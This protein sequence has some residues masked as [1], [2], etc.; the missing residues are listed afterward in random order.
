[1]PEAEREPGVRPPGLGRDYLLLLQGQLVS[2]LGSQAFLVGVM[3]W[4]LE[5]TQSATTMGFFLAATT[6]PGVLLGPVAGAV[7]DRWPRRPILVGMD[8]VRGLAAGLLSTLVWL[9]PDSTPAIL[10]CL[11]PVAVTYGLSGA[12]FQPAV[13]AAV[14]D[15]VTS[16][17]VQQA[18]SWIHA[19]SQMAA[20]AG[21]AAGGVLYRVVGAAGLFAIDSVS[22]LVAATLSISSHRRGQV[23]T[24]VLL[25][26]PAAS[27]L[28]V[29]VTPA[30]AL[31]LLAA[32]GLLTGLLNIVVLSLVQLATPP[33][34]RGRVLGILI[35][36]SGAATPL[37]MITGGMVGDVLAVETVFL[38][39][40]ALG[41]L[42]VTAM[43]SRR[44]LREFLARE[45]A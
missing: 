44:P 26:I 19:S 25:A 31:A 29:R 21:Q 45:H 35:S 43:V 40:A 1:M 41:M 42:Y 10:T 20:L 18:N 8:L 3:F 4:T 11:L 32:L 12:L 33:A 14:P 38:A 39:V 9:R 13:A 23:L 24:V 6:L 34:Y 7:V 37:G 30:G 28:L 27:A 17:R 2:H 5:A 22:Y 15:L 16:G 36:L